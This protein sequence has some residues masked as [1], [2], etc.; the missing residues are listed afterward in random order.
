MN[1]LFQNLNTFNNFFINVGV[2]SL[3]LKTFFILFKIAYIYN[4]ASKVR[5]DKIL[6]IVVSLFIPY[7]MGFLSYIFIREFRIYKNYGETIEKKS[8][9]FQFDLSNG[10]VRIICILLV[11][12]LLGIASGY[13]KGVNPIPSTDDSSIRIDSSSNTYN[14]VLKDFTG[15]KEKELRFQRDGDLII[16][17]SSRINGY[18]DMGIYFNNSPKLIFKSGET[19]TVSIPVKKHNIYKLKIKAND[20][21]GKFY[22]DWKLK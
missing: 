10:T 18:I 1:P 20:A 7:E 19:R 22:F 9:N 4:D 11:V 3:L 21:R 15:T 5:M 6:W 2:L 13:S 8:Y 12:L 16:S 17:Y 14:G